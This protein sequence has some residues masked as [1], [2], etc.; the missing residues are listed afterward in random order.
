MRGEKASLKRPL[1]ALKLVISLNEASVMLIFYCFSFNA[2]DLDTV[3]RLV[4]QLVMMCVQ[5]GNG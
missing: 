4:P 2:S 1:Q 5:V 3:D